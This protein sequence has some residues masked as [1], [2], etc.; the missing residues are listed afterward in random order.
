MKI[1]HWD[2]M[3][4]PNFGYQINILPVFQ[5]KQ[6]H[7]VFIVTSER[8]DE[9]PT[10]SGFANKTDINSLD[11]KFETETGVK[12][13]RLPIERVVSGRVIYKHGYIKFLNSLNADVIMC[14]TCDTLSAMIIIR[15]HKKINA[16]LVFDN[17]ML[18]MASVNP[19]RRFFRIYYK[20]FIAPIIVKNK[21]VVIRTQD[22][23]Y[24]TKCL[25]IPAVQAPYISFG[26]DILLYHPDNL[27]REEF[28]KKYGIGS[29]DFVIVY[30]GKTN[31]SKGGL[32]LAQALRHKFPTNKRVVILLVSNYEKSD[33]GKNVEKAFNASEN[34]VI[35]FGTQ[36]YRNLA[37]FYQAADLA[38][39]ARQCSLSFFDVQASGL[40]VVSENNSVNIG[41]V[42]SGNGFVFEAGN[43]DSFREK[44]AVCINMP[45]DEYAKMRAASVDYIYNNFNYEN[46]ANQY[47]EILN[48]ER[49]RQNNAN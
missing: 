24:V 27:V 43:I 12:I 29:D 28:R 2:E 22:D 21:F 42:Q 17:H 37:E 32:L 41:R 5:Q 6:G 7:D 34:T 26:T 20:T 19:L 8:P 33:Y 14:H 11:K 23:P 1:V 31:T 49:C 15:N 45:K 48:S 25:G 16:P 35:H 10:F 3:F 38:V 46:I 13:I 4:H 30:A 40:P 39:F 47:T 9:H 18:E 36:V 44:I